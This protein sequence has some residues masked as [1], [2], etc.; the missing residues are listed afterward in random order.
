MNTKRILSLI[1]LALLGALGVACICNLQLATFNLE[2]LPLAL[3]IAPIAITEEQLQEFQGI[4][5]ELKG[6]WAEL[7]NLPATYKS[8]RDENTQMKQQM[9][10]V[11]RLVAA[12]HV[13][14]VSR[15]QGQ[16]QVSPE[17]AQHLAASF[18]LHCERSGKLE[19]LSSMP[20]QRDALLGFA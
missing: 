10:D 11:R 4:L 7:K 20:V 1:G 12:R 13:S 8:L 18:I 19:A 2:L 16:G 9:T 15:A 5:G 3:A 14:P 17:C 6:G